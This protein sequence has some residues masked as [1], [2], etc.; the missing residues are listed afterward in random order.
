MVALE[1]IHSI[2]GV[3]CNFT[4]I[5]AA[6]Q[7]IKQIVNASK[8]IKKNV[9]IIRVL[10]WKKFFWAITV[11]RICKSDFWNSYFFQRATLPEYLLQP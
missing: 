2:K 11:I 10:C 5:I 4:V 8:K 7:Y 1:A 3:V 9:F 6:T